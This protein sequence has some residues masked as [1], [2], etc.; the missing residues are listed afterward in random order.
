M[1]YSLQQEYRATAKMK[2]HNN[3]APSGKY[4]RS[5]LQNFSN[6][7]EGRDQP[8][9]AFVDGANVAHFGSGMVQYSQVKLVVDEF[10]RFGENPMVIMPHKSQPIKEFV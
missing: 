4:C 9:T 3:D 8:F 5:Q 7:L 1:A 6:W 2:C 10:I